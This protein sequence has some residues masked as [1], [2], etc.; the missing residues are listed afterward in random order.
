MKIL[1]I[2]SFI[3]AFGHSISAQVVVTVVIDKNHL[4]QVVLNG[5]TRNVAQMLYTKEQEKIKELTDKIGINTSSLVLVNQMIMNSLTNVNNGLKSAI[6]VK[7]ITGQVERI[8]I[9]SGQIQDIA[10]ENPAYLLFAEKYIKSVKDR[11]FALALDVSGTILKES[12]A[13]L[14]NTNKRDE[15]IKDISDELTII[16]ASLMVVRQTLERAAR[17]GIF[18]SFN[19]YQGFVNQDIAL[20]NGILGKTKAL[21]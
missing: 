8:V 19:P 7:N 18:Q 3:V 13:L 12:N 14:M 5:T 11:S 21:K 17:E 10:Q 1:A 6:R 2:I 20:V 16:T 15:F 4:K 9:I